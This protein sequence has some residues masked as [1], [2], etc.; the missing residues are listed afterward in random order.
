[1][2]EASTGSGEL[3]GGNDRDCVPHAWSFGCDALV[4]NVVAKDGD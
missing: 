3:E 1:M 4:G 2:E